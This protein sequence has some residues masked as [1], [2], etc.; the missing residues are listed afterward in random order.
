M[1]WIHDT[2]LHTFPRYIMPDTL[3]PICWISE[4][5]F[6]CVEIRNF[7]ILRIYKNTEIIRNRRKTLSVIASLVLL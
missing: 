6:K 4:N 3:R 2:D 5:K 1:K 7:A